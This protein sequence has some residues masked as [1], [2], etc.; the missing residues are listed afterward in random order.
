MTSSGAI[1]VT[2]DMTTATGISEYTSTGMMGNGTGMVTE[3]PTSSADSISM[4]ECFYINLFKPQQQATMTSK[5]SI[6]I[7]YF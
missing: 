3:E 2:T 5:I 6:S 7:D 1:A 4:Y